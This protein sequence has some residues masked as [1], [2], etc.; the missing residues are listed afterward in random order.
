MSDFGAG[1]AIGIG[2]GLSVGLAA[3]KK[4]K[5]WSELSETEKKIKIALLAIAGV[6][7]FISAS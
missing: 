2:A 1:L 7:M 6:F 5:P 4:K 3:G